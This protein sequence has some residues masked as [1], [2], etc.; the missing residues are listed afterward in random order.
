MFGSWR[1]NTYRKKENYDNTRQNV[2]GAV[3]IFNV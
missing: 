3:T 1:N 2:L